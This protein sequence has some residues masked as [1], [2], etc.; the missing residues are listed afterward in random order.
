MTANHHAAC[1]DLREHLILFGRY[2]RPGR[3]KTRLI[4]VLGPAGAAFLQRKLAERTVAAAKGCV[5][6]T[7]ARLVFHHDGG[8]KNQMI[9]WLGSRDVDYVHQAGGDLGHRMFAAIETAFGRGA[10]RVVLVGTDIPGVT[11]AILEHA[12]DQLRRNEVVLGPSTDGGYWLVGM[13]RLENLFTEIPWSTPAVLES[14]LAMAKSKKMHVHLLE[15]LTDLDEPADLDQIGYNAGAYLSVIIPT[16]NEER[17]LPATL[18]GALSADTQIIVSDGGSTDRTRTLARTCGAHVVKGPRGRAGQLNRGAA[19]ATGDVLLFLH[20]DT[21]LPENYVDH[22]FETLMNRQVVL[23]AF[24]FQTD[25]ATPAR[26]WIAFWTN[27]RA[28]LLQLPYGDQGLFL[29]R[30]V[31]EGV[32]GFPPTP[33]AEDLYLVRRLARRGRIALAPAAAVTSG[34]RWRQLGPLRTTLIN[35]IIA[36]GCLAGIDPGR[37]APLYRLPA[38]KGRS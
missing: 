14:T 20:A 15:P 36:G 26:R 18:A 4:P 24:R 5:R 31:F 19:A 8:S 16:L 27:L 2:P 30:R 11:A 17:H 28:S 13:N 3:T 29:A 37:L 34:R 10:H 32:G 23:G 7:G 6:R 1:S 33:I 21:R 38:R 22:I 25:A 12:F 35:T 9:A